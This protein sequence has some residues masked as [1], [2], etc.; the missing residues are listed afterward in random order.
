MPAGQQKTAMIRTFVLIKPERRGNERA[1]LMYVDQQALNPNK[2]RYVEL[3]KPFAYW[4][5]RSS[6]SVSRRLTKATGVEP[7]WQTLKN[8][9][10]LYERHGKV[11]LGVV[12]NSWMVF[13]VKADKRARHRVAMRVARCYLGVG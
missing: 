2:R 5:P 7:D 4:N 12:G 10:S 9:R 8:A 11:G 3:E 1:E 13:R 6:L